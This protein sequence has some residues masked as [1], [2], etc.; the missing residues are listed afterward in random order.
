M[1]TVTSYQLKSIETEWEEWKAKI[2][3][4]NMPPEQERGIKIAFL[5]GAIVGGRMAINVAGV[6]SSAVLESFATRLKQYAQG[7]AGGGDG[8][9]PPSA[10]AEP[11]PQIVDPDKM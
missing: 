7:V 10:P 9:V 11:G 5:S 2:C 1:R 3:P 6:S 8:S 4:S